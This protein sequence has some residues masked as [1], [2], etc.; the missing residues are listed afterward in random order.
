VLSKATQSLKWRTHFW[1]KT[2]ALRALDWVA[3]GNLNNFCD[4]KVSALPI[5]NGDFVALGYRE[6]KANTRVFITKDK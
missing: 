1:S 6:L 5:P 3:V 4:A 2:W